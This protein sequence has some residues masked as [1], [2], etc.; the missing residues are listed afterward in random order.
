MRSKRAPYG[1]SRDLRKLVRAQDPT[2][3]WLRSHCT[4]L[5]HLSNLNPNGPKPMTRRPPKKPMS[6]ARIGGM[7]ATAVLIFLAIF[8]GLFVWMGS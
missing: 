7:V 4:P 8:V 3:R 1:N 5:R 2:A 6:D